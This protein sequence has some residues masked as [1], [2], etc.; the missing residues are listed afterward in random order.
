[1]IFSHI[2]VQAE[3]VAKYTTGSYMLALMKQVI[4]QLKTSFNNINAFSC[5]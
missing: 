5:V 3:R 2:I 1:M 4:E